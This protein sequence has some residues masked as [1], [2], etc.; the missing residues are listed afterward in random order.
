L[1]IAQT[2]QKDQ[3]TFYASNVG[4]VNKT[5]VYFVTLVQVS[6]IEF[7]GFEVFLMQ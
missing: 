6:N 7:Y 2:I 5:N 1:G 4:V 3:P